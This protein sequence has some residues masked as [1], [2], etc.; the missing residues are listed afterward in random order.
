LLFSH[1][2]GEDK[3]GIVLFSPKDSLLEIDLVN[4][5]I[6]ERYKEENTMVHFGSERRQYF[7][8]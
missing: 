8:G 6:L 2:E 4:V 5:L 7:N 3:W 1:L